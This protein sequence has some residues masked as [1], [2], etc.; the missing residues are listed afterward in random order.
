V[1]AAQMTD[2]FV[3]MMMTF[4]RNVVTSRCI[5]LCFIAMC[6]VQYPVQ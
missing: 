1:V 5:A 3:V 4:D 6:H 2:D